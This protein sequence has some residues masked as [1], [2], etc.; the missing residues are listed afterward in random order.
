MATKWP[1][2]LTS[3]LTRLRFL[4][5]GAN[6]LTEIPKDAFKG[7]EEYIA[8]VIAAEGLAKPLTRMPQARKYDKIF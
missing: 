5:L 2:F 6:L 7:F 3:C 8:E 4:N 1:S